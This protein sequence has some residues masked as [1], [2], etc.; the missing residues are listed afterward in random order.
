MHIVRLGVTLDLRDNSF[1]RHQ[2]GLDT[3]ID[4]TAAEKAAN[5]AEH[6]QALLVSRVHERFS[7]VGVDAENG[8]AT[9]LGVLE[10][11]AKWRAPV[12]CS[13]S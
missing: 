9:V 10:A 7:C 11:M 5:L 12:Q 1:Q 6:L 4:E 3:R 2:R 13:G 8:R